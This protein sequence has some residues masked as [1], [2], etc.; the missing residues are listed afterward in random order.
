MILAATHTLAFK[1]WTDPQA[2]DVQLRSHDIGFKR[3]DTKNKSLKKLQIWKCGSNIS[4]GCWSAHSRG[5]LPDTS[6]LSVELC[7]IVFQV[8]LD[9]QM[10]KSRVSGVRHR[11]LQLVKK[12]TKKALCLLL[13]NHCC[14]FWK[15]LLHT[16]APEDITH[17]KKPSRQQVFQTANARKCQCMIR[18]NGNGKL[19]EWYS[20]VLCALW[21]EVRVNAFQ[22]YLQQH[23]SRK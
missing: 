23:A 8:F 22:M 18:S 7:D 10:M 13:Q 3:S 21:E 5:H 1:H 12:T 4:L 17:R 9:L 6:V 19:W 14:C 20:P 16:C 2:L 11:F 15:Q